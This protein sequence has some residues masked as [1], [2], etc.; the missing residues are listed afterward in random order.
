MKRSLSNKMK[1]I[2]FLSDG[3]RGIINHCENCLSHE[4]HDKIEPNNLS[5]LVLV[6]KSFPPM[7][8]TVQRQEY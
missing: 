1:S 7:L 4:K 8:T 3:E 5:I 2:D 6:E